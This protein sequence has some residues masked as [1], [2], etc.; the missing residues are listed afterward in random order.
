MYSALLYISCV[1]CMTV[2]MA[3]VSVLYGIS[4]LLPA[5]RRAHVMRGLALG[6]G[7]SVIHFG[8]RPFVKVVYTDAADA[9]LPG[10]YVCNHRSGLDAFLMASFDKEM[11]QIVNG[12]PMRLPF[13]GLHARLCGYL[14][15]TRT[16]PDEY[17]PRFR[18]LLAQGVSIAV[19]PEGH[20]SQ[21]RE[22]GSFHSGIFR[23]AMELRVPVYPCS[24]AGNE[25]F[26][27]RSFRFHPAVGIRVRRLKPIMPEEFAGFPS[28]YV[29]KKKVRQL[30]AQ[31]CTRLDAELDSLKK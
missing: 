2:Y 31:E 18:E 16:E 19:F 30:I 29:F 14:D 12:W 17:A 3:L 10:I 7:K 20:R 24:I 13:F 1:L 5:R 6:L 11:I 25:Q 8:I 15:A 28:A 26:P 22:M 27:D 9:D 4:L 21:S 23:L